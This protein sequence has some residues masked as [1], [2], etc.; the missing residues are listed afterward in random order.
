MIWAI[1]SQT[2]DGG[3]FHRKVTSELDGNPCIYIYSR[4]DYYV[5]GSIII[6]STSL[7]AS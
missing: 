2:Q 6:Q 7:L 3:V 1:Y 4:A 5:G